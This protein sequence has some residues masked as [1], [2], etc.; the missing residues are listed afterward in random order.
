MDSQPSAD[1]GILIQV[2]GEMSNNQ[3]ISRKFAQTFFLAEQENG[4][5]VLNDIFIFLNDDSNVSDY[6]AEYDE[7]VEQVQ[8]Q[9]KAVH[10]NGKTESVDEKQPKTNGVDG[11]LYQEEQSAIAE[12]P[13]AFAL[14]AE[15]HSS[16]NVGGTI[17]AKPTE[18]LSE[19]KKPKVNGTAS[20][21]D[22]GLSKTEEVSTAELE[23]PAAQEQQQ[24]QQQQQTSP[25]IRAPKTWANMAAMNKDKPAPPPPAPV[26]VAKS[27][28]L[29]AADRKLQSDRDSTR[30]EPSPTAFCKNVLQKVSVG[31]FKEALVKYGT[32][33]YIDFNRAKVSWLMLTWILI[34]EELCVC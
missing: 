25:A 3:E 11:H 2:L 33:K 23:I 9:I 20:E 16:E 17:S 18:V 5:F 14:A 8:E 13:S 12:E 7:E 4:Y 26:H 1:G 24:Q 10:V 30:E 22:K 27:P 28:S 32:V 29:P 19:L 34:L 21:A 15:T 31:L 6:D